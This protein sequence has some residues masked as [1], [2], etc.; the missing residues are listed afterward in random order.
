[1]KQLIVILLLLCALPPLI[2]G[3]HQS[4]TL[5]RA[6]L[7][8][9]ENHNDVK[10]AM[11]DI[12]DADQNIREFTAT[13]MPKVNGS[14]QLQHF[15]DVPTS[16]LPRGSFFQGDPDQGIP[17]NPTEDLEV[18]FGVKNNVTA[19]ISADL[20]LFDGSFF[21]GLQAAR[22][23]KELVAQEG[24]IKKED[25]AY[26]VAKAYLGVAVA[27][28]NAGILDK[29]IQNLEQSLIE[30]QAIFEEGF[31]EKQDLDRLEL[32]LNN[33]L[34]EKEKVRQVIDLSKNALKF[35]M[36]YPMGD[37]IVI[38]ETVDDLLIDHNGQALSTLNADFNNRAAYVALQTA[39]E[40]N[41]LGIKRVQNQYLPV[42]RGFA[43]YSQ[44][45]Q[46][47][48]FLSGV[49]FPTTVVGL[50][51]NVP[52][53]DGFDKKSRLSRARIARDHHL[54]SIDNLEKAITLEVKNARINFN[55]ALRSL[56][57]TESNQALAQ[58]IYDTSVIKYREGVGSSIELTQSERDLYAQQGA[59]IN[60]LYDLALAK[61]DVEKALGNLK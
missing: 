14:V 48:E 46:G 54:I 28:E 2:Q 3:Q 36:G 10:T 45:L 59:R 57:A 4:F 41:E 24:M 23:F 43:S 22:L 11:L 1:M 29:N 9:Q 49:W 52:I 34:I 58:E 32:S 55:N 8:G 61:I 12:A 18:Q 20:L 21:V 33:L 35:S 40:L 44:V 7:Y 38:S 50:S 16:I 47:N 6:I 31:V 27:K 17:P 51:L 13:G 5:E 25:I 53:F 26:N 19:Q 15:I 60:A 42:L 39:N 37:T 56:A 30:T